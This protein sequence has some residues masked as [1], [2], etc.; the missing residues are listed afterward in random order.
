MSAGGVV[1]RVSP[2][3]PGLDAIT[4]GGLPEHRVTLVAGT[5]GS[6]KTIFAAQFLADGVRNGVPGVFVTFEER[7]EVA[8]R[9]LRSLGM[10]IEA[11]EADDSWCFV[12]AAPH[13]GEQPVVVGRYDLSALVERVKHAV[14]AIGA[15]RVAIDSVGALLH[16][17]DDV[18][19]ARSALFDLA[20]E[21]QVMEVTTVMTA[22]RLDDYGAIS[23]LGFEEFVADHVILL[24]N[25]LHDEKRRRTIEV[26]K[27][28]GGAHLKGEHLFTV[29]DGEGLIVVPQDRFDFGYG[30]S[31][32]KLTS[33]D[34]RLDE[35]LRGGYFDRSLILVSGA[36]GTGKSLM[37]AQFIAGGAR[38]GHRGLLLSFE[39]SR[40]Q[41]VR[42]AAGWGVDFEAMEREGLLRIM[43]DAPE[44]AALEDHLLRMKRVIDDFQPARVAIDSLT[45]LQRI[46]TVKSFREYLLGLTFHI[47]QQAMLGLLTSAV[48]QSDAALSLAELHVSTISDTILTLQYVPI[49]STMRRGVHVVKM[50]GSGHDTRLREFTIGDGGLEIHDAFPD[51]ALSGAWSWQPPQ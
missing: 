34:R 49:G 23:R 14:G 36:T 50:R 42:N 37:A 48:S 11:W 31:T 15:G 24:R 2:G 19:A 43:S 3:I 33:G 30:T 51:E 26:L 44:S 9:N 27:L 47:K 46:S 18:G 7:P 39:E 35:M 12:D 17:Y 25:A 8:R 45:A 6:G 38:D 1:P 32:T 41:L 22:E 16:R 21:L 20:S 4:R 5:A 13:L 10:D 28:R 40:D 29:A